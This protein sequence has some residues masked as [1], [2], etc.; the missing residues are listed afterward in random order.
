M[1]ECNISFHPLHQHLQKQT[2]ELKIVNIDILK[3]IAIKNNNNKTKNNI[4]NNDNYYN[5]N[6]NDDYYDNTRNKRTSIIRIV[7]KSLI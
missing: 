4:S 5:N 2:Q 6:N 3:Q 7:I 1:N